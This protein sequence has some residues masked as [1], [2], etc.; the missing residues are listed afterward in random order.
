MFV[1]MKLF[2]ISVIVLI[3]KGHLA[4]SVSPALCCPTGQA[5][6]MTQE[7]E[8]HRCEEQRPVRKCQDYNGLP[9]WVQ[10]ENQEAAGGRFKCPHSGA[11]LIAAEHIYGPHELNVT[12][13]GDL[14]IKVQW[15]NETVHVQYD[16][17]Q[18]CVMF[19]DMPDYYEYEED[20]AKEDI[21]Q[22]YSVC[23]EIEEEKGRT[24]TGLF[25]PIAIFFSDLLIL[26]TLCV[27]IAV[28][29]IRRN[30][31]GKITIGFLI[32]A[33]LSYFFIGVHY[34]L[35]LFNNK[36]I[37]DTIFC[38]CLGYI[39]Q[40]TFI[41]FFF[42]MSAMAFNVAYTF[43]NSFTM[44]NS[45]GKLKHI[46][47]N[48]CYA[49]GIP[50]LISVFTII[51]DN[52]G[53][54]DQILPNMGR[55]TCFL[56]DQYNE[57][58]PYYNTPEFLYL[59]LIISILMV[60]NIVCFGVTGVTLTIHWSQMRELQHRLNDKG[61]MREFGIII[62]LFIIMGIPWMADVISSI[63][64]HTYG[65][66]KSFELRLALDILNLLT[67]LFIFLALVCKKEV[68]MR[69]RKCLTSGTISR[70]TSFFSQSSYFSKSS[71]KSKTS[72]T[73][74]ISLEPYATKP[75]N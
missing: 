7:T 72:T 36:D 71:L 62:K 13:N 67:G 16:V 8:G 12:E 5:Y 50:L 10:G 15:Q 39:I 26:I 60:V 45:T 3:F 75:E 34:S 66:G 24:F 46:V 59:Y 6:T 9:D 22:F 30:L 74:D 49:Q 44:R 56:G 1:V 65:K 2:A 14:N 68:W 21:R 18:H 35:D 64:T 63:V 51:M 54:C 40:H 58:T 32:N 55:F 41:A 43:T 37:L 23:Y 33:F 42:W 29:E 52:F 28:R 47:V 70:K 53:P 17:S 48:I 11:K 27:Y 73:S 25:Y 31:F 19:S 20:E 57:S 4:V 69:A 61:V 38:K